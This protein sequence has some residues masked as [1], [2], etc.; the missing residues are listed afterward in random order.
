[1][2]LLVKYAVP[3]RADYAG[4]LQKGKNYVVLTFD[5]GFKSLIKNAIPE[6]VKLGI[7]CAIF[8]PAKYLGR[9]PGWEFNKRFNDEDEEIMTARDIK[10]LPADSV[11]IGSHSLSHRIM[12]DLDPLEVEEEFTKSKEYLESLIGNAVHLF[13]FPYGAFNKSLIE[14]AL[15]AGY[16]RAFTSSYEVLASELNSSAVGRVRVDPSDSILEFKL[17]ILGAYKWMN[18]FRPLKE[19]LLS[20]KGRSVAIKKTDADYRASEAGS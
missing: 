8:F 9:R 3:L 5:D 12:T 14:H 6:L 18:Y 1:M 13:S 10:N 20:L 19:K 11:L 2:N 15:E 17:K 4:S 7:P 16:K